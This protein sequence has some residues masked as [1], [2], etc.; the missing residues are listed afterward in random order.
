MSSFFGL[1][2]GDLAWAPHHPDADLGDHVPH[3]SQT[4]ISI[5][6]DG[7]LRTRGAQRPHWY[8]GRAVEIRIDDAF[9]GLGRASGDGCNCLID[10]L[11]QK[12]PAVICHVPTVRRLL[13]DRHQYRETSIT[14]G[15]YLD[16][17][18]CWEDIV[19]LLGKCNEYR[20]VTREWAVDFRIVCVDLTLIGHGNVLPRGVPQG[21]RTTLHIARVNG[22]HFIP[23]YRLHAPATSRASGSSSSSSACATLPP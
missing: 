19:N 13:E 3:M 4:N 17:E 6:A 20:P 2:R 16:L 15:D 14:H 21:Q 23:L 1:P 9:F 18:D 12:L 8:K 10:T 11:R 5:F 7:V 22:N